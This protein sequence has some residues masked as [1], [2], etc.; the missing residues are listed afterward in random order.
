[1]RFLHIQMYHFSIFQDTV[2]RLI[3]YSQHSNTLPALSL[4]LYYHN[5]FILYL[6]LLLLF[7]NSI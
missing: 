5:H 1:M 6:L 2:N 3:I 7:I 4:H